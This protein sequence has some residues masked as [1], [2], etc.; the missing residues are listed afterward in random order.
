MPSQSPS[1]APSPT[2]LASGFN[3]RQL[4]VVSG[5]GANKYRL[6]S[7]TQTRALDKIVTCT[8]L[9]TVP[10]TLKIYNVEHYFEGVVTRVD[11]GGGQGNFQPTDSYPDPAFIPVSQF[12]VS[13]SAWV[14]IPPGTWTMFVA[15][16]DGRILNMPGIVFNNVVGNTLSDGGQGT[17]IIGYEAP[18]G[19]S[20]SRGTF[21]VAIETT[22]NLYAMFW[23]HG[24]GD[25]FELAVATGLTSN[26]NDFQILENGVL[27]WEVNT[28]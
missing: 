5:G 4:N 9:F 22:V 1:P 24:G 8:G 10:T 23:E 17:G 19:H 7:T 21:S 20:N 16:D 6:W 3:V 15:S 11:M 26:V 2:C 13:V 18:T 25:S 12:L 27:G 14:T 28:C